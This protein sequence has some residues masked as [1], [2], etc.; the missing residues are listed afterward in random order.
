MCFWDPHVW[1]YCKV[2]SYE[3][4]PPLG[5]TY[6]TRETWPCHSTRYRD[7]SDCPGME[8]RVPRSIYFQH[9]ADCE[10]L[11][12]IIEPLEVDIVRRSENGGT[13]ANGI[14]FS[15]C[16]GKRSTI[17]EAL[18]RPFRDCIDLSDL[19]KEERDE[20]LGENRL[21]RHIENRVERNI[22]ECRGLHLDG[23][24]DEDVEGD[25]GNRE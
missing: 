9:S 23:N 17:E 19:T 3:D 25:E 13:L 20:I 16:D 11:F 1:F 10:G 22:E 4:R 6:T 8:E 18:K 15:W 12:Q 21:E 14:V 2:F 24:K 5:E 7:G